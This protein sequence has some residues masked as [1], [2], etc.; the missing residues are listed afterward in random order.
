M[1]QAP[2]AVAA[3]TAE[4]TGAERRPR[5]VLLMGPATYRAGAFLAAAERLGLEV[6]HGIDLPDALADY[7]GVPLG[8]D[9]TRPEA[10]AEQLAAFAAEPVDAV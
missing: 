4:V 7:W 1:A 5:V 9:F 3:P 2:G 8:L 6:V 10:A